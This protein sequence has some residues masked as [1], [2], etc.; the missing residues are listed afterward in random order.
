MENIHPGESPMLEGRDSQGYVWIQDSRNGDYFYLQDFQHLV[1]TKVA[2]Y[3][4]TLPAE[5]WEAIVF[6]DE[7]C[8]TILGRQEFATKEE[9]QHSLEQLMEVSLKNRKPAQ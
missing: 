5:H 4:E 8:R 7:S 3:S 6:E 1:A 2:N 9:A